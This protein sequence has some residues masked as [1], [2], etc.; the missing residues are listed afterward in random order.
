MRSASSAAL[1]ALLALGAPLA[2][3]QRI[4]ERRPLA[5]DGALR[6]YN[7]YGSVR[8]LGWAKDSVAVTGTT[9]LGERF[10]LA[11]GERGMKLGIESDD[12]RTV[13][14]SHLV[15]HVPERARV[16]VKSASAEI[17]VRDVRG[18]LDLYSVGA[19]IRV[20]GSPRELNAEAMDGSIAIEGSPGWLRAKTASGAITLRGTSDDVALSSVSGVIDVTSGA[21]TRGRFET[22]TGDIRFDGAFDRRG[23]VTFESHSGAIDLRLPRDVAAEFD[24][25]NILGAIDN[26]LSRAIPGSGSDGRGRV[27]SF[28]TRPGAAQVTIRSFKGP[29]ALRRK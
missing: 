3:Q 17:E 2:A 6:I 15:V 23:T 4:D 1:L 19:D 10:F 24:I 12:Q 5:A 8:V 21:I 16:W 18:G 20:F 27:L 9:S 25:T 28:A 7:L 11:A 13:R 22:V 14:G 29:V 26:G